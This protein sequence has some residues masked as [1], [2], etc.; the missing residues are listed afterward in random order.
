MNLIESSFSI[1]TRQQVRR[2]A[3]HNVSELVAALEHFIT[4]SNDRAQRS[5]GPRAL[6]KSSPKRKGKTLPERS[7]SESCRSGRRERRSSDAGAGRETPV[8]HS[9]APGTGKKKP[10]ISNS[11]IRECPGRLPRDQGAG[12]GA[13]VVSSVVSERFV[14]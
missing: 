11:A 9:D 8:G 1:L 4:G 3:Y 14:A 2:G 13:G 10:P 5:S 7:T 12:G 6:T